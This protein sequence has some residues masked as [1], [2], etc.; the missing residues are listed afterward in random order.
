MKETFKT[1][2]ENAANINPYSVEELIKRELQRIKSTI[3][4]LDRYQDS[5]DTMEKVK[6]GDYILLS[7]ILALFSN[8]KLV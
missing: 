5:F 6:D 8:E 1:M 7:D 4:K 2:H 3:L